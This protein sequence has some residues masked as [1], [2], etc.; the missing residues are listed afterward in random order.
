MRQAFIL[1]ICCNWKK[2]V[3]LVHSK[4][5][6]YVVKDSMQLIFD[7]LGSTDKHMLWVEGSGH[8]IPREPSREQVF[9]TATDFIVRVTGEKG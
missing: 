6:D 8:V 2:P 5:D 9:K 1:L 4:D 7:R 3:S